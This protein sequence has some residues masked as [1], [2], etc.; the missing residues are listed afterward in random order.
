MTSAV[1]LNEHELDQV[2]AGVTSVAP[3]ELE[4][5]TQGS[6]S[7]NPDRLTQF[8]QSVWEGVKS[9]KHMPRAVGNMFSPRPGRR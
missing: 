5:N 4:D 9:F 2:A 6:S 7:G 1:E 3:V 8:G